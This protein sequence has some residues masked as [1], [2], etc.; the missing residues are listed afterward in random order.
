MGSATMGWSKRWSVRDVRG[1]CSCGCRGGQVARLCE[2]HEV[3]LAGWRRSHRLLRLCG[4]RLLAVAE[5]R[6]EA[7]RC[8][9][10]CSALDALEPLQRSVPSISGL[11]RPLHRSVAGQRP[12]G[13]ALVCVQSLSLWHGCDGGALVDKD[14][15]SIRSA[16]GAFV[17]SLVSHI[18]ASLCLRAGC[19]APPC[20]VSLPQNLARAY[21]A[22]LFPFGLFDDWAILCGGRRA[23]Q[24]SL[25][26]S[27][28]PGQ[29]AVLSL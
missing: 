27:H 8:C 20:R 3:R 10:H 2:H 18:E 21:R 26:Q 25:V 15:C 4:V 9:R 16:A 13:Q 23:G 5:C 7:H 19:S 28:G 12:H 24:E 17:V 1:C 14:C 11:L 22:E 29:T 6:L